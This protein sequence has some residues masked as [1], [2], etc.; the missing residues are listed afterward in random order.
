MALVDRLFDRRWNLVVFAEGT[1]SRD[2]RV[3]VLRP[4]AAVLAARHQRPIVPVHIA[5][6]HAAMPIGSRW[7]VRPDG[8]FRHALAVS[9]GSP[10]VVGR[11]DDRFE[12]ME[13]VRLFMEAHGA[14]TTPD[15]KLLARRA[16]A[17]PGAAT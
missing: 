2:G 3:G 8:G 12:T 17:V 13:R 4:G 15:P 16:A 9:I 5:G 1:R 14:D 10:I 11:G 6:T 7:M